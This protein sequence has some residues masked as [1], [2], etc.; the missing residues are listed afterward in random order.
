[1]ALQHVQLNQQPFS[2]IYA[3]VMLIKMRKHLRNI[4]EPIHTHNIHIKNKEK[5][6]KGNSSL[7]W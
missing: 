2:N 5:V 4:K 3:E 6:E 7:F 1:M